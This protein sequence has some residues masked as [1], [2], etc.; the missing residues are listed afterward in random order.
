MKK[1]IFLTTLLIILLALNVVTAEENT[2]NT[3]E[4]IITID[5]ASISVNDYNNFYYPKSL[6]NDGLSY[7]PENT[8]NEAYVNT[9]TGSTNIVVTDVV[10]PGKNGFNL[11][12]TRMYNS[13]NSLLYEAYMK[14]NGSLSLADETSHERYSIL[15]TGWEFTFPYIEIRYDKPSDDYFYYLH[16]GTKGTFPIE[17]RGSN[18]EDLFLADYPLDDIKIFYDRS[19]IH[20]NISS[21][22]RVDE[23]DG[24]KHYFAKDG[25]LLIQQDRYQNQIEYNF[26][27]HSYTDVWGVER[28]YPYIHSIVDSAGRTVSFTK[29]NDPDFEKYKR[30]KITITDP[31]DSANTKTY[32]YSLKKLTNAQMRLT[33]YSQYNSLDFDE[34]ILKSVSIYGIDEDDW[35]TERSYSYSYDFKKTKLSFTNKNNTYYNTYPTDEITENNMEN[36]SGV[37]NVYA[38][39][40]A[41]TRNDGKEYYFEYEPSIKKC[42]NRGSMIFYKANKSY[43][44]NTSLYN[45]GT[46]AMNSKAY[47]Y[48]VTNGEYDCYMGA[49][50]IS[51]DYTVTV[52][53]QNCDAGKYSYDKYTYSR[54]GSDLTPLVIKH[55]DAGTDHKTI[56]EYTYDSTKLL[57]LSAANKNYSVADNNIYMTTSNAYTYDSFGDVLT[58]TINGDANR[59]ITYTY[60][61]TYHFP[62]S[63]TYKQ[64]ENTEIKEEYIKTPDG[65]NIEYTNIY[66]NNQLKAKSQYTYDD[67]DNIINEK[68]YMS[69]TEYTE[70]EYIYQDNLFIEMKQTNNI[71]DND[72]NEF[73]YWEAFNYD[74]WGNCISKTDANGNTTKYRY[75]I[76]DK[77]IK[78]INPDDTE[79]IYVYGSLYTRETDE[80][81]NKIYY[82]YTRE[83][84]TDYIYSSKYG[85]YNYIKC[86]YTPFGE[87]ET[88]ITYKNGYNEQRQE[89]NYLNRTHYTYDTA[90]RPISKEVYDENDVLVYKELY[91]YEITNN[92]QKHTTTIVGDETSPSVVTSVYYDKYGNKIKTETADSYETYTYDYL[93]NLLTVKSPKA[94]AENLDFVKTFQYDFRGNVIKTTDECGNITTTEYDMLGRKVKSFDINGYET[95]YK[96]DNLNRLLEVKTPFEE[97]DGEIYY[98]IKKMW[99]D[100]NGNLIEERT[101][102]QTVGEKLESLLTVSYIYDSR[103]RLILEKSAEGEDTNYTQYYYDK[104]GNL[105][106]MYTGLEFPLKIKGLDNVE[107]NYDDE[108]CVTKYEYDALGRLTKTTDPMGQIQTTTY[109]PIS[110]IIESTKD[111]NGQEFNYKYDALGNMVEK[112]LSDGTNA[113]RYTYSL[114]G[115]LVSAENDTT[116][117][118]YG[119]NNKGQLVTETDTASGTVKNYAYD[120][121]GNRTNFTLTKNGAEEINQSYSYDVLNRITEVKENNNVIANYEYDNEGNRT[122]TIIPNGETTEYTYNIANMLKTKTTGEVLNESYTYY[123]NGNIASKTINGETTD[124]TYDENNR[125]IKENDVTYAFDDFGNRASKTDGENVTTYTYDLNNRLTKETETKGDITKISKYFYDKNGNLITKAISENKPHSKNMSGDYTVSSNSDENIAIYEYNCYNELVG[126]DT[127]GVKTTYSYAPD[128]LRCSK[129][130]DLDTITFV[131]DNGN[132]V[133]EITENGTNKYY[134]GLEIIKNNDNLYYLYNGQGDVAFLTNQ[135]G[136]II[137]NYTFDAYGNQSEENTIYNPFGYRGEYQDL[138]SGLI[139]LRNRYYDPSIGRFTTEDPAKDGLNWYAYCNN[140]PVNYIDPLGLWMTGDENLPQWAQDTITVYTAMW[141]SAKSDSE[142]NIAH[143]GADAVRTF[144]ATYYQSRSDWG[145]G[146]S[147]GSMDSITGARADYYNKLTYHHTNRPQYESMKSLQQAEQAGGEYSDVPYHFV[148]DGNGTVYEGRSLQYMGAHV[149]HDNPGNIGLALMGNFEENASLWQKFKDSIQGARFSNP[150]SIQVN[151]AKQMAVFLDV[152]YGLPTIG[153]HRSFADGYTTDCPGSRL[154]ELLSPT[155]KNVYFWRSAGGK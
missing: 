113:E 126:V 1:N 120:L 2:E 35:Y 58:E 61:S 155:Y 111:K 104:K 103:N 141:N 136:E 16:F 130:T 102:S 41:S 127:K 60:D 26:S 15:G 82:Y 78:I 69:E 43:E 139:Y 34:W 93:G 137:A 109:E 37:H 54:F 114:T 150:T 84:K 47:S 107:S 129:T 153:G 11:E 115:K 52:T 14:E 94:N 68:N 20:N 22:Y 74:I 100:G 6:Y 9:A 87:L 106:R 151:N 89:Q 33:G 72:G 154:T 124:Y 53:D 70:T 25:R 28:K 42:G 50:S 121:N 31:Y 46:P 91:S 65:K 18:T 8:Y 134:R 95:Q 7:I 67:F 51:A 118:T 98:N 105:L 59:K 66:V 55:E 62:L 146:M 17:Y 144:V 112:C 73:D 92:Y 13:T 4:E 76:L 38:L 81:G 101:T 131:Y 145:A 123:V 110:G 148:I 56:S 83:N 79:K 3:D 86:H 135:N 77:V 90:R 117:I 40:T 63:K 57:L 99:Y 143:Q 140:N 5:L 24:T 142:R 29:G 71:I 85:G 97:K 19:V 88:E 108:Y 45:R 125:L 96:Y 149:K 133:E 12:I 27:L 44:E 122:K 80:L 32:T 36:F 116:T 10:L 152:A 49:S 138:C 64:D 147:T 132:V 48:N 128:G 21:Y 75:N 119:Y 39:L 30:I 23:K